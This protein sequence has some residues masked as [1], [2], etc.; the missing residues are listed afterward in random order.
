[1]KQ[2]ELQKT[3]IAM[4][5]AFVVAAA[6]QQ[7]AELLVVAT[8]N[9]TAATTPGEILESI[10]DHAWPLI[11]A[12]THSILALLLVSTSWIMWSKSQGGGHVGDIEDIISVKYV[13]LLL[14][15][16]LVT[17]YFA[18]VK[19][20]EA[21]FAGY[22]KENSISAFVK[23]PSARPEAIQMLW[24]FTVFA[25][26]DYLVDVFNSPR[27]PAPSGWTEAISSHVQGVMTYC[28]VSLLCAAG[29]ALVIFASPAKGSAY[30]AIFG[31]VALISLLLLF[32]RG[33]KLEFYLYKVFPKE[34]SRSNT[35][36]TS[37]PTAKNLAFI[38]ALILIFLSF[39]FL[40][41]LPPCAL[42]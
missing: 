11:A 36:R 23:S 17:L 10:H 14:E 7:I 41:G 26:W 38:T 30:Q 40:T 22:T 9:W 27:T 20:S 35:K 12:A 19:S 28:L 2:N 34:I 8:K 24:I 3:F 6:A 13:V 37:A 16:L 5:F 33:K 29:A 18:I 25:V 4:L 1:M 21:D 42:E 15:V 31:D 32:V 39:T